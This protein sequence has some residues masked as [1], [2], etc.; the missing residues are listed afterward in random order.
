MTCLCRAAMCDLM[1]ASLLHA[2]ER[3]GAFTVSFYSLALVRRRD[4]W[5][6]CNPHE[7]GAG[8]RTRHLQLAG[9]L[10]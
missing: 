1:I 2:L 8:A 3:V 5:N 7:G 6:C 10:F 4:A 9:A